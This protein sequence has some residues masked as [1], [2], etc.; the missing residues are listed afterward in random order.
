MAVATYTH[1]AFFHDTDDELVDALVPFVMEGIE[2]DE[3]VVVVVT[4][5]I[6]EALRGRI[7]FSDGFEV[8]DSSEVYTYPVRTLAGYVDTVRA[9]TRNGRP[10][11]VAGQP[12]WTGLNA[13][14]TAEWTCVEAACN[15][16]FADSPLLMLCLYDT[17]RLAPSVIAAALRTHPEIGRGAQVAG[18]P[19]FAPHA[20]QSDV[21]ADELPPRPASCEVISIFS[22]SDVDPV[23]SFVEAFAQSNAMAE[24]RIADL[25]MTVTGLITQATDY[26]QGP[27]QLRIWVAPDELTYEI[28]SHGSLPSPFAGYLPPSP[29]APDDRGLWLI[30]QRCDLIAVREHRGMT[31]V[32]LNFCD[33]LIPVRPQCDGLDELLGV[34]ALGACD[35]DEMLLVEQHLTT[36]PEC[37]G[38]FAALSRVAG[39][40]HDPGEH[41][42]DA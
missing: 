4:D 19:Q 28:E 33:F 36:C 30:A 14:E 20:H 5:T 3:R 9:G 17:S 39:L 2:A 41:Q 1:R 38:E 7:G 27:A 6:G 15:L 35:P 13:L 32:R 16:V 24:S 26:R 25:A 8:W 37:R 23:V 11:R 29:S 12:V 40:M 10:M 42:S 18:N 21:R 22:P 34:C 31:T